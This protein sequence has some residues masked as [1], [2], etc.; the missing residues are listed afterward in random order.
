[1]PGAPL[2]ESFGAME[3][4]KK[5][6][7]FAQ[8]AKILK[9]LQ[10]YELPASITGF[11]GVTFDGNGDIV[12]TAMTSVGTGP[13]PTYE[14][15]FKS[16]LEVALQKADKNPYIKGWRAN[17]VRERLDPFVERGVL[18]QFEDLGSKQDRV[19]IHA[20]FSKLFTEFQIPSFIIMLNTKK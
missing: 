16:R 1:M 17:G 2:D 8:M 18:A 12:S 6:E 3:L 13:C 10:D 19:I 7:I 9:T 5:R 20:D 15:S 4:E 14:A 11:G